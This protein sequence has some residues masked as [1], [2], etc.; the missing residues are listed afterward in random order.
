M[1]VGCMYAMLHTW[2]SEDSLSHWSSPFTFLLA[3][4]EAMISGQKLLGF[5]SSASHL[6]VG[7]LGLQMPTSAPGFCW[8]LDT[9]LNGVFMAA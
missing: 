1:C 3:A 8:V 9:D 7:V 2:R 5:P 4:M 6:S